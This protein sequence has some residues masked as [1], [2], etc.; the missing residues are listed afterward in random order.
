MSLITERESK[1]QK[2]EPGDF[3]EED[4]AEERET[5]GIRKCEEKLRQVIALRER[6]RLEAVT[7]DDEERERRG[8]G[9]AKMGERRA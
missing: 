7:S 4:A 1:G 2:E 5:I 9:P 3:V 6:V 8:T